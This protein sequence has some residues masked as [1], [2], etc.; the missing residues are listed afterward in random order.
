MRLNR[1]V[2][3]PLITIFLALLFFSLK[4]PQEKTSPKDGFKFVWLKKKDW[5][6]LE[7]VTTKGKNTT[8][9]VD[10]KTRWNIMTRVQYTSKSMKLTKKQREKLKKVLQ[11]YD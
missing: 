8:A 5:K 3:I 4:P 2:F 11:K 9:V 10:Y 6:A 7:K 1:P